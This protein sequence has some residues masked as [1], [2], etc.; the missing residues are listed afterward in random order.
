MQ[1]EDDTKETGP[2]VHRKTLLGHS[3]K[4]SWWLEAP[5]STIIL[6]ACLLYS[7][8]ETWAI[9]YHYLCLDDVSKRWNLFQRV[10]LKRYYY[11]EICWILGL[12]SVLATLLSMYQSPLLPS[13]LL[14]GNISTRPTY[15]DTSSMILSLWLMLRQ[16]VPLHTCPGPFI[17]SY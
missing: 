8:E 2:E 16:S 13:G 10:C 14:H 11:K 4:T 17:L 5:R 12:I 7:E 15:Y 6:P 1:W 9:S 3:K